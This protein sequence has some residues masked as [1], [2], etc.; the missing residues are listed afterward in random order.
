VSGRRRM[1]LHD[2]TAR[3]GVHL[4]DRDAP[5]ITP[6][7]GV[8]HGARLTH[9]PGTGVLVV[10]PDG[11]AGACARHADDPA[12]AAWL[13]GIGAP[14]TAATTRRRIRGVRP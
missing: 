1:R 2:L 14:L 13:A 3:S 5:A 9:S 10:R 6:A 11:Y 7:A 8:V 4:L 12:V